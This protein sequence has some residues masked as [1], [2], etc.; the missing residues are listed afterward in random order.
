MAVYNGRWYILSSIIGAVGIGLIGALLIGNEDFIV[1]NL[2]DNYQNYS[3]CDFDVSTRKL[4]FFTGTDKTCTILGEKLAEHWS[5][6]CKSKYNS[7]ITRYI[8]P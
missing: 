6:L 3:I 2:T 4:G 8:R 7:R 5:I 1:I